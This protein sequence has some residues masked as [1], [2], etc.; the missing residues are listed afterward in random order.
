MHTLHGLYY[1]P[2][3]AWIK[4]TFKPREKKKK[5][6]QRGCQWTSLDQQAWQLRE[7]GQ[8][9]TPPPKKNKN[10]REKKKTQ[11]RMKIKEQDLAPT[12]LALKLHNLKCVLIMI[13]RKDRHWSI[14]GEKE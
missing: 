11:D 4:F 8:K 1:I 2:A 5:I 13:K 7:S 6:V 3:K 10:N 14:Y 9:P 12:C